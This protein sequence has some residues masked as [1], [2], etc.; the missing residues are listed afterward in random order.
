MGDRAVT[1]GGRTLVVTEKRRDN[2][3][4]QGNGSGWWEVA[5][6]GE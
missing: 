3:K 1:V 2:S 6:K 4:S 5:V